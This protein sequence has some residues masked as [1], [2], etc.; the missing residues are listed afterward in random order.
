MQA[1]IENTADLIDVRD[2][3][4]RVEELENMVPETAHDVTPGDASDLEDLRLELAE[5]VSLLDTLEGMGGD[6]QWRGDWYPVTLI[7]DSYFRTYAQELAEDCGMIPQDAGWPARC[8]DWNQAAR[9]LQMDY[10][11]VE[12]GGVTYWTR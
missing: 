6:E 7:R 2:I 9:E 8:I 5:L 10:S 3:I 4:A 11:S 1:D 12:Y